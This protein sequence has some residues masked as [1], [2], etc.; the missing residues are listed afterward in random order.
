MQLFYIYNHRARSYMCGVQYAIA[1]VSH[2]TII[3]WWLK[4]K[5]KISAVAPDLYTTHFVGPFCTLLNIERDIKSQEILNKW[6]AR[7]KEELKRKEKHK[8]TNTM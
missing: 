7:A 8:H 3:M 5:W 6:I 1:N 4:I 2:C